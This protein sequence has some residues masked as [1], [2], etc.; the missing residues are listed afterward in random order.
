[1]YRWFT[2]DSDIGFCTDGCG[3]SLLF[4]LIF[5]VQSFI[6][7]FDDD[8][9]RDK[10]T[11]RGMLDIPSSPIESGCWHSAHPESLHHGSLR[12]LFVEDLPY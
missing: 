3:S 1:V 9:K 11:E 4:F 12:L 2:S 7:S 6:F 5:D 10:Y 8:S